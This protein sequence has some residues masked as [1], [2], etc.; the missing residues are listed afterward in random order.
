M[1]G[2]ANHVN[3]QLSQARA[4]MA[5][6]E[7]KHFNSR[8]PNKQELSEWESRKVAAKIALDHVINEHRAVQEQMGFLKQQQHLAQGELAQAVEK[9]RAVD[10]ELNSMRGVQGS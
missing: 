3:M 2:R 4:D 7:I 8:F 10:S 1:S 9:L 6:A 5:A